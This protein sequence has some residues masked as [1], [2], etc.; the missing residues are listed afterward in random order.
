MQIS[1][2]ELHNFRSV[3]HGYF[4]IKDYGL[5]IGANNVGK[6]NVIDA[7]RV[8]YDKDI[9]FDPKSDIPKF[10]ITDEESWIDI[11]FELSDIEFDSVRDE[12]KRDENRIKVRK[13]LKTKQKGSDG[14]L[15]EGIFAFIG[16]V[17]ADEHFY[18]AKN[19][20]QGKL[21][22]IIYIPAVS[23]LDDYMKTSGPSALRDVINGILQKLVKSSNSFT[24]LLSAFERHMSQMK[25]EKTDDE[26]SIEEFEGD[27]NSELDEWDT[28]FQIHINPFSEAEIVRNLV[29]FSITDKSIGGEVSSSRF[30]Q[31]FQRHLIFTLLQLAAKYQSKPAPSTDKKE[32][33]PQLTFLLFEEPEAFLHPTQQEF[34]CR[35]LKAIAAQVGN[36]VLLSTHS[37]HFVS[38]S[39]ED[40]CSIIRLHRHDG[41]T[42][43]KQITTDKLAEI[44]ADNQ[45][46]NE[47]LKDTKYAADSDDIKLDMEIIKYFLWLDPDRCGMFF[48][49]QVLLVEGPTEKILLNYLIKNGNIQPPK[50]GMF[51]LDCIGKFNVHRF[52]NLMGT[53][54]IK[55]S[56]I[57]D[58]DGGKSPHLEIGKLINSSK[59]SYTQSIEAIPQDIET[60]L[61]IDKCKSSHKK[62]QHVM[63]RMSENRISEERIND[64]ITLICKVVPGAT[65][66][67]L[68]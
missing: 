8:F 30:G 13:F 12:Y 19:I 16:D 54:G 68:T 57:I 14:K 64:L 25:E 62:P 33:K 52:M 39:S 18:G 65:Q 61:E 17:V 55:H 6:T 53:L 56:V 42:L 47:L 63:F 26:K 23:K 29:S 41:Q 67:S 40:L 9:K 3:A 4:S 45:E 48:A 38:N 21:G 34:L 11:E 10:P 50:G 28:S 2:V 58:D 7:I 66:S 22:D 5:L 32:F 44:F 20:Q 24:Q 36:Q 31:G 43:I 27:I 51:I 46:I 1:S 60:F 37:T 59:N 35:S 15:K 49:S